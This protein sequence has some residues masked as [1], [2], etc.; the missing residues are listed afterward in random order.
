M[1]SWIPFY[2]ILVLFENCCANMIIGI[3]LMKNNLIEF[4]IIILKKKVF[5]VVSKYYV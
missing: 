4:K 5:T 1:P 2:L 3:C